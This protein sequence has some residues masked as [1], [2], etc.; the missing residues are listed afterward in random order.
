M[1]QPK[2]LTEY[3]QKNQTKSRKRKNSPTPPDI[4]IYLE[5][6]EVDEVPKSSFID[7]ERPLGKKYEKQT[8]REQ[9]ADVPIVEV[10]EELREDNKVANAKKEKV[11]N[12]HMERRY[13]D[14]AR[15]LVLIAE[16]VKLDKEKQQLKQ[17]REDERIMLIDTSRLELL[18]K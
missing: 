1:T 11:R 17:K 3:E 16:R 15:K 14:N 7:L 18:L 6:P 5:D 4:P 13:A 2:W 12:E 10:L 9:N 8:K